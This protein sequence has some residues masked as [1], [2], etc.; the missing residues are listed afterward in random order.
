V[1]RSLLRKLAVPAAVGT[2]LAG[3]LAGPA[4]AASK[5]VTAPGDT[6][7]GVLPE[8]AARHVNDP[9]C[10]L[11]AA[12]PRPVVLVHGL[13]ATASENWHYFAPYLAGQGYCVYA[14]TY[15]QD[16]RWPGR[17]GLAPMETSAAQLAT[18]VDEVLAATRVSRLDIVGHSE[19]GIMPR[20]YLK[21]L[22]GAA[23]VAHFVA[24]APPNHGTTVSGLTE[25]RAF[26]PGFDAQMG[27][28]CG[29][30]PEFMPGSAFLRRL[31]AGGDTVG[32]VAYTVLTSRYD[33]VVTPTE[34][35]YLHG[36]HVHNI[37]IQDVNPNAYPDHV[38]MAD[39]PTTFDLTLRALQG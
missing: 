34:T 33:Y 29:S 23:K 25:L 21:F 36:P 30:C 3:L 20:Y 39:D 17:G 38:G 22:G 1:R 26:A 27:G 18:F 7:A 4:T 10:H 5:T 9:E 31:N 16:P 14:F 28:Y 35:S 24:W 15:G 37:L 13:G 6:V 32:N 12:H 2:L 19:G 8:P 11:T